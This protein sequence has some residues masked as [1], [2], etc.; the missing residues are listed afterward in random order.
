MK[1]EQFGSSENTPFEKLREMREACQRGEFI[2]VKVRRTSGEIEDD[3]MVVG[4]NERNARV[5]QT[6]TNALKDVQLEDFIATN[7]L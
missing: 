7:S 2:R 5:V 4:I 6:E 1:T 3:W